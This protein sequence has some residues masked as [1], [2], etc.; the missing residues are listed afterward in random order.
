VWTGRIVGVPLLLSEEA[1]AC[2]DLHLFG[3]R[4]VVGRVEMH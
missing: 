1:L 4:G 3:A 2:L